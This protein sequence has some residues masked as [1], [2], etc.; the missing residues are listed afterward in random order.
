MLRHELELD[1]QLTVRLE[2]P[3][4]FLDPVPFHPN[5][6]VDGRMCELNGLSDLVVAN[7]TALYVRSRA[8]AL[9]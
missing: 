4:F 8:V 1:T 6:A 2:P 3:K 5:V 7:P 9:C